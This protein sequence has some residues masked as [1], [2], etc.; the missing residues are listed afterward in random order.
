[1]LSGASR[2]TPVLFGPGKSALT[3]GGSGT[4]PAPAPATEPAVP[5]FP[6]DAPPA[7]A[8]SLVPTLPATAVLRPALP[9]TP[10]K[11]PP[12]PPEGL[13]APPITVPVRFA[14]PAVL[15]CSPAPPEPERPT[16]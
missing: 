14:V 15:D 3:E 11:A 16:P 10:T 5:G 7:P 9:P 13:L 8:R 6:P 12:V 4:L 2:H 1:M